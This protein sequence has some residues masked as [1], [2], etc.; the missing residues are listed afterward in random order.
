MPATT[1]QMPAAQAAP[2]QSALGF[3]HWLLIGVVLLNALMI[4]LGVQSLLVSRETT[5]KQVRTS[6]ANL[7]AMLEKNVSGSIRNIDI[8]LIS[9]IDFLEHEMHDHSL[10]DTDIDSLLQRHLA[11]LPELSAVRVSDSTGMVLWGKDVDRSARV[12]YADR[13]FFKQHQANPGA[14]LIVT[15]PLMGRI[16]KIWLVAFTRSYRNADGSFG[17]VVSASVP[18]THFTTMLSQLE[19]GPHGSAV[20]RQTDRTLVTRYPAVD[21][22]AGE[23]GNKAA[24]AEFMQAADSGA[25]RGTYHALH[26]ADGVERTISFHRVSNLPA[27]I[28]V[29]MAPEDYFDNWHHEVRKTALLLALFFAASSIFA[30]LIRR[31]WRQHLNDAASLLA[32]ESRYRTYIETA[33]EAIFVADSNGRYLDVNPAACTLVGYSRDELLNMAITDLAPV[34]AVTDHVQEFEVN[35]QAHTRDMELTLKCKDG[36]EIIV[37]LRTTSLPGGRVMGVCNN[38]TARKRAEHALQASEDRYRTVLENI[39]GAV[40][41]CAID[42]DWSVSFVSDS[43]FDLTGYPASDFVHNA[44]RTFASIIHPDDAAMVQEV[45]RAAVEQHEPYSVTYRAIQAS[46]AERWFWE[47]GQGYFDANGVAIGL[48]GVIFDTTEQKQAAE[49]LEEYRTHL[50]K[51]VDNRTRELAIAKEAAE[52]A[53]IAKSAFLANMSHEIRTPLN[54][55]TGMAHLIRRAGVSDEQM[56]RLNK[57]EA[58]GQHLLQTINSVLDL[59]KIE[60]DRFLIEEAPINIGAVVANVGSIVFDQASAKNLEID[61][62]T[63]PL[64]HPLLGDATRLLQALLNYA[65]NAIKF[66]ESGKVVLRAMQVTEEGNADDVLVRFEVADTGIGITPEA[67]A[68]LFSAFEQADNSTT[69]KYGGTGLGLAITRKIARLMGGDAGVESTPGIGSTFWFTAR[70]KRGDAA[71][72][73]AADIPTEPAEQILQRDYRERRILLAEDEPINR[74]IITH[75]LHDVGLLV[76]IAEDGL[77]A[78]E[79]ASRQRYALILMDMQMPVMNGLDATRKI[80]QLPDYA[81]TPILATTANAFTEDKLRCF[82]AGMDDFMAKPMQP[83]LFYAM[84]LKW[85]KA[86]QA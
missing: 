2:K 74:E 19:L 4:S 6:T 15:E 35:K 18:V 43:I 73:V 34:A 56:K 45:V 29:G 31:F 21:G 1:D 75:M 22:P 49:E 81:S 54:A 82:D 86:A 84:L 66:T 5:V 24:T 37:A 16:S 8:S 70:F 51:L 64:P 28:L 27:L 38:I 13:E 80:R 30:W 33:P 26:A 50:E 36:E 60:A 62:E 14:Q 40:F 85:L 41:R 53:N 77:K 68:R 39:P 9:I 71:N 79:L 20:I 83:E 78:V 69:R 11:Q 57:L 48:D 76:D 59:S 61:I 72:A 7:S 47:R 12:T 46:G 63:H 55:I 67:A 3:D 42:A 32:S 44:R 52:G 25:E 10:T 17:G 65:S 23:I 58:A